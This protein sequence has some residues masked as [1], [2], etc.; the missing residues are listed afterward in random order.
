MKID[1]GDPTRMALRYRLALGLVAALAIGSF[2]VLTQVISRERATAGIIN[3]SG[4]QRF[5][6]QRGA[7]YVGRLTYPVTA[8]DHS[9]A[10][11]RLA[12]VIAQ[13]RANH[14]ALLAG[15]S[16]SGAD[17]GLSPGMAELFHDEPAAIDRRVRAYL[18]AME[19]VLADPRAPVPRDDPAVAHVLTEGPGELL[20]QLDRVVARFQAEG[21]AS[22][23][24]LHD[25][26]VGLLILTL[27][28]LALEAALVFQPMASAA[29]RRIGDLEAASAALRASA[30]GLEAEV[31][32]RT[33]ELRQAKDRAEQANIAKARFLATAGH[34]LL[35]P[36]E[37]LRLLLGS[38]ARRN[39]DPALGAPIDDMRKAL[40]GM[41]QML[42]NLLDTA[43]LDTGSVTPQIQ[44]VDAARLIDDLAR[45][46][47]PLAEDK[48]LGFGVVLSIAPDTMIL[49]D[50]VM[51]GRILRNLL[52]NAVRYTPAGMVTLTAEATA[53][54]GRD[55]VCFTVTDTGPGID[56]ADQERIFAEFTQIDDAR[57][58]RST[59]VGLGLSIA[60]RMAQI[61][62]HDLTL[63]SQPG[64]GARFMLTVALASPGPQP[65]RRPDSGAQRP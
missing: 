21:E 12:E 34:D 61:L 3:V 15:G 56:P 31:A 10:R 46:F 57:R 14:L 65:R 5:L 8:A 54:H 24:R 44:P 52:G 48:G 55:A 49:T 16:G 6:S 41:R 30:D 19:T 64:Q 45:E 13:M 37:S 2:V 60:R 43:R 20:A 50:P 1:G 22:V 23:D 40:T 29:R 18:A 59:G 47:E 9:D 33:R 32:G 36:I 11:L 39:R 28:T 58:D 63:V 17:L 4:Q 27:L 35:Q 42:G 7:L 51:T 26:H 38:L 25:L 62:E 53:L